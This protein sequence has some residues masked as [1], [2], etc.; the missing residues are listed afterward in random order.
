[1]RD[2]EKDAAGSGRPICQSLGSA[3]AK[4]ISSDLKARRIPSKIA[5][6]AA[7]IFEKK[8]KKSRSMIVS[9]DDNLD[10]SIL[11]LSANT[12]EELSLT[13]GDVA[14]LSSS[15]NKEILLVCIDNDASDCLVRMGSVARHN[16][17]VD[18]GSTVDISLCSDVRYIKRMTICPLNCHLECPADAVFDAFLVPYFD[19]EYRP[20]KQGEIFTYTAGLATGVFRVVSIDP[21][22]YGIVAQD[23]LISWDTQEAER[24]LA[25]QIDQDWRLRECKIYPRAPSMALERMRNTLQAIRGKVGGVRSRLDQAYSSSSESLIPKS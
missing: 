17:G 16:L 4:S 3:I 5:A 1:M 7:I 25:P 14:V 19:K 23:T 10:N 24:K 22:G 13:H 15:Q 18:V 8:R 6:L 20:L 21:L 11:A 2:F 9:G 12:M